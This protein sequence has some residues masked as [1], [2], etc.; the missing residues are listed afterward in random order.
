MTKNKKIIIGIIIVVLIFAV[1]LTIW[2]K[3]HRP[4]IT[5]GPPE[6]VS[7]S[8]WSAFH[9]EWQPIVEKISIWQNGQEWIIN[10]E[11]S[12]YIEMGRILIP[13]L[14]KLN[15]QARCVF[16]EERIQEIKRNN[17]AIELVFKQADDFPISQWVQEEE[18]YH[19]PT[20][21]NGY[22]ILENLKSAIF[23]LEDNLEAHI[24]VAGEREDCQF[25]CERMWGCWA[26]QQ[27]GSKEI[28][29]A[30]IDEINRIL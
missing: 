13:T 11:S 20:D 30:W 10:P 22:R 19:I 12:E 26:I 16:S 5:I 4:I 7:P 14:H 6:G 29:K 15:L 23:V 25:A 27:E 24:L 21:E 2:Q 8:E 17:K 18:R 3:Y 1:A 9:E 28:D